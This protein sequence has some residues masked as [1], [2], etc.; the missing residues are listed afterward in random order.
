LKLPIRTACYL[1][2]IWMRWAFEGQDLYIAA[3]K[4]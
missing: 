4:T 2:G 3:R 1:L